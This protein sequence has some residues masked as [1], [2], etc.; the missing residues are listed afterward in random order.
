MDFADRQG[1]IHGG[2]NGFLYG[3]SDEG[4]P[5][6]NLLE[7]LDIR[8]IAQAAP[9]GEQHPG[10]NAL[11]VAPQF[12]RNGGG[13]V[14][15]YMQE[16]YP[17]WPYDD[18]GLEDYLPKVERTVRTVLDS[19]HRDSFVYVPFNEPDWIWYELYAGDQAE[20]ERQRDAFFADWETVY[21]RI[22]ELHPDARIAG[23]NESVYDHR[24][25]ADFLP[26]ARE[27][28]LLPDLMTWHELPTTQLAH[29]RDNY[30]DYRALE[31]EVGIDPLPIN[32]NEWGGRRDLSV[33]GRLLQFIAMFED[34]DV[35][36]G[37]QAYWNPSGNLSG[38]VS[39]T[40]RPGGGWW[41][42]KMY[43]DLSGEQATLT[44]PQPNTVDTAQGLASIDDERRQARV[45][46]GGGSDDVD[47]ALNHLDADTFGDTVQ[48]T[49]STTTWSGYDADA[50]PPRVLLET[51]LPLRDGALTLPLR[52]VDE[53]AAYEIVVQPG[54][55]GIPGPADATWRASHEAEDARITDGEIVTQGTPEN[56]NQP[57][58]S[59]TRDV[60]ELDGENSAV[61]FDIT[62]PEDGRY[63]LGVLYGNQ[64][65]DIAQ[66]ALRVDGEAIGLLDYPA[67]LDWVYRARKDVDLELTAG[68]HEI[69]LAKADPELGTATGAVTLDR[70]DVTAL[71]ADGR[72]VP[73]AYQAELARTDFEMTHRYDARGQSGAGYVEATAGQETT[74][75][76]SV[77][78][79][80]YYDLTV[81]HDGAAQLRLD[82]APLTGAALPATGPE[83]WHDGEQRVFLTA[84]AHRLTVLPEER[85]LLDALTV[86]EA[87][88]APAIT[89]VEAEDEANELAGTAQRG[90]SGSAS[91]GG[92]VT[93]V[94]G[95]EGNT[96]TL[97]AIEADEAG[98]HVLVV[99]YANNERGRGDEF[100]HNIVSRPVEISVNGGEPTTVWLRNTWSWGNFW[101]VG[102]PVELAE[103][104]NA[105]TFSHPTAEAA[106]L[107]RF[108]V[109]PLLLE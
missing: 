99:H 21:T 64:T 79:D 107:D 67:T 25:L 24:L 91:G 89:T 28:D 102:V 23:P 5:S 53:L 10:G 84:G 42:L 106:H 59:G 54:G 109:A 50:P 9:F 36:A 98:Q 100:N 63:R 103:G 13:Y 17:S 26:W 11:D 43:A 60:Q 52:D 62:V 6:D 39:Q 86:T 38:S 71:P 48:V 73:V 55:N 18:L 19:P 29:Y 72:P 46:V 27:R 108:D 56:W 33:P 69:T 68:E 7:P 92:Q 95:G 51:E 93:G 61:S 4:V 85:V 74:F 12:L 65:G 8:S 88:E 40:N 77:P 75:V 32:I 22:R 34:T 78:S 94:G 90:E 76:L 47:V 57:A 45:L 41:L 14:Q 81:R 70:L 1:P 35:D 66:Q 101:A 96:L 16:V 44:P 49:V 15:I 104:T 80:G 2:G 87:A 105:V 97:P 58:A 83:E 82:G 3:M 30:A 37:G 31:R 20:Y